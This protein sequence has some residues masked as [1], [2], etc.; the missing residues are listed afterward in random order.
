MGFNAMQP[1]KV[2]KADLLMLAAAAVLI[3]AAIVWV[4]R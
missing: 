2:K 3:V 1:G 4:V